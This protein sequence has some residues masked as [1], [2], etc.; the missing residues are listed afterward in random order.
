MTLALLTYSMYVR[1]FQFNSFKRSTEVQLMLANRDLNA[2][3]KMHSFLLTSENGLILPVLFS[4]QSRRKLWGIWDSTSLSLTMWTKV[5]PDFSRWLQNWFLWRSGECVR[6]GN[7]SAW[8]FAQC[9][10]LVVL[11]LV[12]ICST[13]F[14]EGKKKKKKSWTTVWFR[15]TRRYVFLD[16]T[17]LEP[18]TC[19]K[20]KLRKVDYS[21][22]SILND[23]VG[24]Y[25]SPVSFNYL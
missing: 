8:L 25:I 4:H 1:A 15:T 18:V 22:K 13:Q 16:E 19:L 7:S 20:T 5:A 9:L 17:S 12:Q 23:L 10:T 2:R 24:C 3:N 6:C 21:S 11:E 14:P